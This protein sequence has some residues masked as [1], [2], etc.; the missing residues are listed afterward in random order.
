M[1][2]LKTFK[3]LRV[4]NCNLQSV[5]YNIHCTR[6]RGF[7]NFESYNTLRDLWYYHCLWL[8]RPVPLTGMISVNNFD[9]VRIIATTITALI[10][11]TKCLPNQFQKIFIL[12]RVSATS[13]SV[14]CCRHKFSAVKL[15]QTFRS[16]FNLTITVQSC[17]S[18]IF[19]EESKQ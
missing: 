14:V 16:Q 8:G 7:V 18:Q 13:T 4:T 6:G 10:A 17:L 19:S 5:H 1:Q 12:F 3:Q 11:Y 2:L 9:D 15:T